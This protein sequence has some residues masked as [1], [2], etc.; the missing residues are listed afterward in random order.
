MIYEKTNLLSSEDFERDFGFLNGD[1]GFPWFYSKNTAYEATQDDHRLWDFS[2]SHTVFANGGGSS[3]LTDRSI[4]LTKK[5]CEAFNFKLIEIKRIRLGMMTKTPTHYTHNAHVDYPF[6]HMTAL[7]YLTTCNGPTVLYDQKF[8]NDML[9]KTDK[10]I[11]PE[12]NK[13]VVFDGLT[14]HSSTTQTDCKQRIVM[15]INFMVEHE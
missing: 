8:P 4:A 3:P 11:Y 9:L 14:Y 2:F 6:P 5:I 10:I 1:A 12:Q 15:N 13:V 7:F